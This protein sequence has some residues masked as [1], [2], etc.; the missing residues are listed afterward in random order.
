MHKKAGFPTDGS[1]YSLRL[2]LRKKSGLCA[3]FVP[4]HGNGWHVTDF[5]RLSFYPHCDYKPGTFMLLQILYR[6]A[7]DVVN[8]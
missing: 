4:D 1:S 5:H 6:S 8:Q 2:P 7:A 3:G